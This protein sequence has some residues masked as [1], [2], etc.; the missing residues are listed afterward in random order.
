MGHH[1]K[2][3]PKNNRDRSRRSST[4]KLQ[5]YFQQGHRMKLSQSKERYAQEDKRN[6]QNTKQTGQKKCQNTKHTE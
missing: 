5:K 1:E 2:T 3:K 6:L 4:Q